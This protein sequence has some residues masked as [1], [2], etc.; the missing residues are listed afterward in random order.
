MD[1]EQ[2]EDKDGCCDDCDCEEISTDD[3]AQSNQV[4]LSAL[5]HLLVEKGVI[6]EEDLDAL[7]EEDEESDEG[8]ASGEEGEAEDASPE[9]DDA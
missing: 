8:D 1:E 2:M 4:V 3:L 5:I 7:L 9:E 6:K